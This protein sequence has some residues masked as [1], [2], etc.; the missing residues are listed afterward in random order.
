MKRESIFLLCTC[1]SF[2]P[3]MS[4]NVAQ[5]ARG[6]TEAVRAA[7][8]TTGTTT[9]TT[10]STGPRGTGT[11]DTKISGSHVASTTYAASTA[12]KSIKLTE[13]VA[14]SGTSGSAINVTESNVTIDL[15]G[16]TI[17][18]GGA[19]SGIHGITVAP[20]VKNTTIKNGTISGF[21]GSGIYAVG[22][23]GSKIQNLTIKNILITNCSNGMTLDYIVYADI[24]DCINYANTTSSGAIHG[25]KL[26][27]SLCATVTSCTANYN[28]T[29]SGSAY[30]FYFS[31][32]QNCFLTDCE[33]SLNSGTAETSGFY[34]TGCSAH[35]RIHNCRSYA[36]ICSA[37][38]CNGFLIESCSKL[39]IE[40]SSSTY[41][42]PGSGNYS[43]GFKL[44]SSSQIIVEGNT[45][46]RN[47]YGF[48]DNENGGS[49][50]NIFTSNTARQNSTSDY[51]RPNG[52][53]LNS[54]QISAK[55]LRQGHAISPLDNISIRTP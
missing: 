40:E 42:Q 26:A 28:T 46:D 51:L 32:N 45:A 1:L 39:F 23:S 54:L 47:T 36:N 29:L 41:N 55:F 15:D 52:V 4:L 16:R 21:T 33:G 30:G 11:I 27:N 44:A 25:I 19:S 35:N 2:T 6:T 7:S 24:R 8:T 34:I 20:G 9:T 5:K 31:A 14:F 18:Y 53:A 3:L 17:S 38:S 43:Y 22:T 50:T 10:N 13:A 37:A 49:F 12:G 48:Y